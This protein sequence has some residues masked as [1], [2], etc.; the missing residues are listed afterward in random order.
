MVKTIIVYK[1]QYCLFGLGR[2]LCH[3][4]EDYEYNKN[5]KIRFANNTSNQ[6][7]KCKSC[8]Y[9]HCMNCSTPY[10]NDHLYYL[11]CMF[12]YIRQFM[13]FIGVVPYIVAILYS[14][15]NLMFSVNIIN[16]YYIFSIVMT[17]MSFSTWLD[18]DYNRNDFP[19]NG[20]SCEYITNK[21]NKQ[22]YY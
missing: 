18:L 9:A 10:C 4:I 16:N 6:I 17:Y 2:G 14:L 11:I 19:H 15:L 3:G 21:N 13:R 5:D 8:S 22:K 12:G 20:K 7:A 1:H